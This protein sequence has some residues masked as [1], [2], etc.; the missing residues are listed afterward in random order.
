MALNIALYYALMT[1]ASFFGNFPVPFMG[2][3][4]SPILGYYIMMIP[5][6]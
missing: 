3:G 2:Y 1:L 5:N 4:I 6:E